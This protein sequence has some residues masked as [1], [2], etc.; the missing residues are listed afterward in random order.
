MKVKIDY[1]P[2]TTKDAY[3]CLSGIIYFAIT[4]F[5][6]V[7]Y[8]NCNKHHPRVWLFQSYIKI[9]KRKNKKVIINKE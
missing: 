9:D 1:Y 5:Y 6:T 2:T 8:A 4:G 3:I 7:L